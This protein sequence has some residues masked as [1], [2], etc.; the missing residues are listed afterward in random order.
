M[1][2]FQYHSYLYSLVLDELLD[3]V[4]APGDL[5]DDCDKELNNLDISE[6]IGKIQ[7]YFCSSYCAWSTLYDLRKMRKKFLSYD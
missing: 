4:Y 2:D 1:T 7:Y 5:C 6:Q 3:N